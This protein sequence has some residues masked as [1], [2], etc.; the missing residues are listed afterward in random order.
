VYQPAEP[1]AAP[2]VRVILIAAISGILRAAVEVG[3]TDE[4]AHRLAERLSAH[5]DSTRLASEPVRTFASTD[6]LSAEPDLAERKSMRDARPPRAS[7]QSGSRTI[8]CPGAPA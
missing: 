4:Q 7:L 1:I 5:P 8:L 2:E 3:M 6:T